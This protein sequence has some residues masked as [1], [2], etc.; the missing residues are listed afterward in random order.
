MGINWMHYSKSLTCIDM[1]YNTLDA[2]QSNTCTYFEIRLTCIAVIWNS[3]TMH[4]S[5]WTCKGPALTCVLHCNQM[6]M[7]CRD[8]QRRAIQAIDMQL[9]VIDMQLTCIDMHCNSIE[10]HW[11]H[12]QFI[13]MFLLFI[14]M[15][16]KW[17][18]LHCNASTLW[19]ASIEIQ[20]IWI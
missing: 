16:F 2:C 11:V 3:S 15:Q 9:Q 12:M 10:I 7:A 19:L 20:V 4:R 13:D 18:W 5:Q 6:P 1:Q 8:M 17:V 14:D